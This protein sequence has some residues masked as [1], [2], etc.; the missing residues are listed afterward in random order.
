MVALVR[1]LKGRYTIVLIEHKIDIIMS[2]S[3]R[4]SVMHFGALIAGKREIVETLRQEKYIDLASEYGFEL[5]E[6]SASF[7]DGPAL[8]V[9]GLDL[10]PCDIANRSE[11][12]VAGNGLF[13]SQDVINLRGLARI[14]DYLIELPA[15]RRLVENVLDERLR[16]GHFVG[17]NRKDRRIVGFLFFLAQHLAHP[18][19]SLGERIGAL[20]TERKYE[21]AIRHRIIFARV[22]ET[23]ERSGPL[24]RRSGRQHI[25]SVVVAPGEEQ[26]EVERDGED[27][28]HSESLH[29]RRK[30]NRN[31][32]KDEHHISRIPQVCSES[33]RRDYPR[34]AER[35]SEAVTHD[36]YDSRDNQWENDQCLNDGLTMS[37]HVPRRHVY[38]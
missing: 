37:G 14:G 8:E 4:I 28:P 18:L 12:L 1:A 35:E 13:R 26:E 22:G 20:R 27:R 11:Q 16:I 17:R 29:S 23:V 36:Q 3:D 6:G 25:S 5:L 19:E 31:G 33:D 24:G 2:V 9:D 15:L 30:S 38:P 34:K 21:V 7:V 32:E 10:L